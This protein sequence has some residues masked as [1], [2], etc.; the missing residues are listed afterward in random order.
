MNGLHAFDFD[1]SAM[2]IEDCLSE[3]EIANKQRA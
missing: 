1:N 3:G 2:Q